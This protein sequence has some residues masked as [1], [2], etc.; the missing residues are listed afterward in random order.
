MPIG[1]W[2]FNVGLGA[3]FRT[4][5]LVEQD[6]TPLVVLPEL[7][8]YG[9][10]FFINNLEFG[11]TLTDRERH[12][13]NLV[14]VPSYDQRYFHRWDPLNFS[15]EGGVGAASFASSQT[16]SFAVQVNYHEQPG[17]AAGDD[18]PLAPGAN[19]DA[20]HTV[21]INDATGL[22]IN[23]L[24]VATEAT[25]QVPGVSNNT[26][27]IT[28][29]A[30]GNLE[31]SGLAEG[32]TVDVVRRNA[33]ATHRGVATSIQV[34][35]NQL[36]VE[37]TSSPEVA[38]NLAP[39]QWLDEVDKRRATVLGGLE[40]TYWLPWASSVHVQA[41]ADVL[42]VHGGH[43]VRVAWTLP[44]NWGQNRFASTLGINWQSKAAVDYYYGLASAE[45]ARLGLAVYA[46]ASSAVTPLLRLDWQRP[47][48]E[49]WSLRAFWQYLPLADAVKQ[50]PL[51]TDDAVHALFLGGVYHF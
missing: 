20:A 12:Q 33:G 9:E 25:Q 41:L 30:A 35:G 18:M 31:I 39:K 51:V 16:N 2:Q 49:H 38:A 5:P 7:S 50:S 10:R 6:D 36:R 15:A 27:V 24:A 40:Y 46:P 37:D 44:F 21:Q 22:T 17:S 8:Y 34:Q 43:E 14:A 29:N 23:G 28:R 47:L 42:S 26:I 4:H 13:L 1:Q 32:D 48:N 19:F 11:F 3:G 45:A